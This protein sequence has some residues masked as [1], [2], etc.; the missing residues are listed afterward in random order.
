MGWAYPLLSSEPFE[1]DAPATDV[2]PL[3]AFGETAGTAWAVLLSG[4]ILSQLHATGLPLRDSVTIALGVGLL[5]AIA[6]VVVAARRKHARAGL[7]SAPR[8]G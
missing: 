7:A 5:V 6:T 4:G 3:I 2:G 1:A 8:T